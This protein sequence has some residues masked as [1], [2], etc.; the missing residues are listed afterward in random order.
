[1]ST[2]RHRRRPGWR[3]LAAVFVGARLD[4]WVPV[5][6]VARGNAGSPTGAS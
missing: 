1:M 3:A 5:E 6:M 4:F 2:T